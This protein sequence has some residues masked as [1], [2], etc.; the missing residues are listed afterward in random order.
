MDTSNELVANNLASLLSTFRNDAESLDRAFRIG[1]RFRGTDD[2]AFQD[3]YGWILVRRGDLDEAL[4]Y[5]EP[6]AAAL[7]EEPLVQYHLG[8]A[9]LGA[10]RWDEAIERLERAIDLAGPDSTL[11]QIATAQEALSEFDVMRRVGVPAAVE[12]N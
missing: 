1:R 8:M 7:A 3:T 2:A 6:A 11:P 12:S 10:E 4:T 5:L 9:Y